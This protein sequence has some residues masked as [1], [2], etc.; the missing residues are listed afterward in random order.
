MGINFQP[1]NQHYSPP[2][3]EEITKAIEEGK[4]YA[5]SDA[6]VSEGEMA[7]FW[8]IKDSENKSLLQNLIYHREW[9]NNS[10]EEAEAITLLELME[11]IERKGK[12][13]REEKI[14]IGFDNRQAYK[15]IVQKLMKPSIYTREAGAE[16]A[17]IK[18]IMDKV[19]FEIEIRLIRGH[20]APKEPYQVEPLTYLIREYNLKARK[21]RE[22]L[23]TKEDIYNIKYFGVYAIKKGS[24]VV[25][26]SIREAIRIEDA[27]QSESQYTNRKFKIKID[28]IDLDARD[29]FN[30][31]KVST[32]VIKCANA[33]NQYGVRDEIINKQTVGR[34]C[35]RCSEPET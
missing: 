27:K 13:I 21:G 31:K 23:Y 1:S 19:S 5:A 33:F 16:I 26:R 20:E 9:Q 17:R 10:T 34:E 25:S 32:S 8:Y 2:Y 30:G 12:H 6:S 22:K 15:K 14:Q 7:R 24:K 28:F 35:P 18:R 29:T 4:A 3:N 11:V